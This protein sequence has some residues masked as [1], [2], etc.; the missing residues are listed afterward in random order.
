M[1]GLGWALGGVYGTA[2]WYSVWCVVWLCVVCEHTKLWLA[3]SLSKHFFSKK[4]K[5]LGAGPIR[6]NPLSFSKSI[7]AF[8]PKK[9]YAGAT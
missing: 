5:D 2:V 1:Y 8:L 9:L 3:I 4:K 7:G 6:P